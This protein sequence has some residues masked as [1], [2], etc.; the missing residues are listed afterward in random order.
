M[1]LAISAQAFDRDS[2]C[3][4]VCHDRY[5]DGMATSDQSNLAENEVRCFCG[6]YRVIT[7]GRQL[8]VPHR[9]N[10]N[11]SEPTV[12]YGVDEMHYAP[13]DPPSV[14]VTF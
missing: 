3:K 14:N 11:P 8:P 1:L 12:Y 10:Q 6:D 5:H 2:F 9:K 4:G 7:L 13:A